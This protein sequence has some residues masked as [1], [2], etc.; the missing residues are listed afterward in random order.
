MN[1]TF[2]FPRPLD[3]GIASG[4]ASSLGTAFTLL[5]RF[6]RPAVPGLAWHAVRRHPSRYSESATVRLRRRFQCRCTPS[7][8]L[9]SG[10][11]AG[12]VVA[13]QG[14]RCSTVGVA[15][16]PAARRGTR[17][18]SDSNVIQQIRLRAEGA[19]WSALPREGCAERAAVSGNER[20]QRRRLMLLTASKSSMIRRQG[21]PCP[22][23][24]SQGSPSPH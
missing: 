22:D 1:S 3:A 15:D 20:K 10:H 7:F 8:L 23:P 17:K 6:F 4:S 16:W 18:A 21:S 14:P 11:Q 2:H 5:N 12:T 9:F 24:A 13:L 19:R